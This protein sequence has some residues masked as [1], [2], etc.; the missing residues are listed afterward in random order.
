MRS[1]G[2][3]DIQHGPLIGVF[4]C[5]GVD[6]VEGEIEFIFVF[7]IDGEQLAGFIFFAADEAIHD[8]G[9]RLLRKSDTLADLVLFH[10]FPG[11]H[12][13]AKNA[14]LP[15]D[16]N[17]AV[18]NVGMIID[19]VAGAQDFG[20]FL[21]LTFRWRDDLVEFLPFMGPVYGGVLSSVVL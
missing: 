21:R 5:H 4:I 6:D 3:I 10:F 12:D 1:H 16:G 17:H 14:V 13:G 15:I 8:P 9:F 19:T 11:Q 2:F 20:R 18:G 7:K